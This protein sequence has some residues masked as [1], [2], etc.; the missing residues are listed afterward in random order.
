MNRVLIYK[1]FERLWHWAQALLIITLA[2]TGFEVH[3]TLQLFGF[4]LATTIHN[5]AAISL[6]VL[7]AFAIFWHFT[8]GE[9]KQYIPTTEKLG[10]M[11]SYYTSGIFRNEPHPTRKTEL[12][13]LNPLQRLT[14]LGFKILIFPVLASTGLVYMFHNQL[15]A[16]LGLNVLTVIAPIHT[17]AA[18]TIAFFFLVH[19]YMTTTGTTVFSN[20]KAM[21]TG[22]EDLEHQPSP[23]DD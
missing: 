2:L 16:M 18:F 20:L 1:G 8:T 14:Y 13:K 22:W 4:R 19:V 11:I 3:G 21:L 17:L 6:L 5:T 15:T 23:G 10:A 9:W 7:V 12:S